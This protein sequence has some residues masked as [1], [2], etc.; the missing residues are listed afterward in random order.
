MSEHVLMSEME[1]STDGSRRRRRSAREKPRIIL[2]AR[3]EVPPRAAVRRRIE[4]E[5]PRLEMVRTTTDLLAN[6]PE[7]AF[8]SQGQ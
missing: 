6:G 1:F 2:A 3:S 4:Q 5:L 8:A 7:I